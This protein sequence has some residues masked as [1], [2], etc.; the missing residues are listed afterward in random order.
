MIIQ[1][2]DKEEFLSKETMAMT[3][4]EQPMDVTIRIGKCVAC[5]HIKIEKVIMMMVDNS[6]CSRNQ[7]AAFKGW[8]YKIFASA[9]A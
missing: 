7:H 4:L 9:Y 8:I 2:F 3:L 6:A 1:Q 5:L